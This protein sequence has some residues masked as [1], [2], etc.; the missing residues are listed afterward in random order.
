MSNRLLNR[1]SNALSVEVTVRLFGH[2]VF[3]R[4]FPPD[5][6]NDNNYEV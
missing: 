5:S 2:V 3:H 4:V 1:V 6:K